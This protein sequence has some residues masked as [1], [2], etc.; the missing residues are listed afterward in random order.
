[1][2]GVQNYVPNKLVFPTHLSFLFTPISA[3]SLT[4]P[5][6]LVAPLHSR[7]LEAM[8][9]FFLQKEYNSK[10]CLVNRVK[11]NPNLF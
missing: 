9:T 8:I 10:P 4:E 5:W 6:K 11:C 3:C 7:A 2:S 1:M